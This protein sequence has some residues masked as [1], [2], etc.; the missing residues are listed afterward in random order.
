MVHPKIPGTLY[1]VFGGYQS[2]VKVFESNDSGEN[3]N[4]ISN[5]LPNLPI[6]TI[7]IWM[8]GQEN[9]NAKE[10]TLTNIAVG[11]DLGIYYTNTHLLKC[12]DAAQQAWR[13]D[14]STGFPRVI[15]QELEIHK[16]KD[17]FGLAI[18]VLRAATYGRGIWETVLPKKNEVENCLCYDLCPSGNETALWS[19][20]INTSVDCNNILHQVLSKGLGV[21]F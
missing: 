19:V 12:S 5:N 20:D 21:F 17:E 10:N 2:E 9:A 3:W 1:A 16:S 18:N 15:V 14:L 11:N 13:E 7:V 8:Q 4:N 6:N